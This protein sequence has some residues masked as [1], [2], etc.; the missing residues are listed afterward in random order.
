[1][2]E[3]KNESMN[4]KKLYEKNF[5]QR[6]ILQSSPNFTTLRTPWIPTFYDRRWGYISGKLGRAMLPPVVKFRLGRKSTHFSDHSAHIV[7]HMLTLN[8]YF[9]NWIK[10]LPW[11][12]SIMHRYLSLLFSLGLSTSRNIQFDMCL[13]PTHIKHLQGKDPKPQ[14]SDISTQRNGNV[15]H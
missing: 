6:N 9:L 15:P 4:S 7:W 10:L 1:M 13:D 8:K 14:R 11:S 5:S 12:S 2:Y 3:W